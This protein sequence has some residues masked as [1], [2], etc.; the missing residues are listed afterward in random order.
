MRSIKI[1]VNAALLTLLLSSTASHARESDYQ[2]PVKVDSDTQ[3]A[4]LNTNVITFLNNVVIHQGSIVMHANK[5]VVIRHE[6]GNDEMIATGTPATFQ[7]TLD[8]GKIVNAKAS[9]LKYQLKDRLVTLTG[10]A[11]LKQDDNKVNGDVIRY[12]IEKQQMMAE[13]KGTGSRVTTIFSP[14]E[15]QEFN[16]AGKP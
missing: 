9:E 12:D 3:Q 2:Q 4:E 7:Q 16:Q 6:K 8:N 14:Q 1:L 15:V 11:E 13:S 10:K 5:V